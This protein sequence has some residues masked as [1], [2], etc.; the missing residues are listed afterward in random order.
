MTILHQNIAGAISKTENI[1]IALAELRKNGTTVNALCFTESFIL[2]GHEQL[3]KIPGFRMASAYSR[4]DKKRGGACILL[5]N[6]IQHKVLQ[7]VSGLACK[8][9]FESTGVEIITYNIALICIYRT[10][11]SSITVFFDK[12][13]NLLHNLIRKF[14]KVILC[15]DWNIDT[16]KTTKYSSELKSLLNNYNLEIHIKTPTRNMSCLDLFVSNIKKVNAQVYYLALSD[17]ETGQILKVP[18]K[19]KATRSDWFESRRDFSNENKRKFC[20]CIESLSFADV[21]ENDSTNTAFNAFHELFTLFF[22]LCFPTYDIKKRCREKG[23]G[24]LTKGLKRSSIKKRCLYTKLKL[25]KS[26]KKSA[27][28]YYRTYNKILKKCI[29][30]SQQIQNFKYIQKSN[31]TCKAVWRIINENINETQAKNEI[32]QIIDSN[33]L[34]YI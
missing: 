6:G 10:P 32:K 24:W 34:T 20:N 27:E 13:N 9:C 23:C 18:I 4:S 1:Y 12:L 30:K 15:G 2:K 17:H 7:H 28:K 14:K 29:Y 19:K 33:N 3:L 16:L 26:N 21:Y 31:N 11:N 5:E 25:A 22:D 8:Y